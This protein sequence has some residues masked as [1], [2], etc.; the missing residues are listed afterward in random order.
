MTAAKDIN[1]W[2]NKEISKYNDRGI[3]LYDFI[4]E[5]NMNAFFKEANK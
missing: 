2:I 1:P 4:S 5:R 3:V